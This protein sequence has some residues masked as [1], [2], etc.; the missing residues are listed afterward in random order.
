MGRSNGIFLGILGLILPGF[1][2]YMSYETIEGPA[3]LLSFQ[4]FFYVV[5]YS[6]DPF[7]GDQIKLQWISREWLTANHW[8]GNLA[9]YLYMTSLILV[10]LSLFVIWG[11][12]RGGALLFLVAGLANLGLLLFMYSN[13]ENFYSIVGRP[14]PIPVGA[15]LLLLAGLVAIRE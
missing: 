4:G 5:H 8:G 6:R 12:V 14:Y 13:L 11:S 9:F 10:V 3:S 7:G 2:F 1:L 15:I